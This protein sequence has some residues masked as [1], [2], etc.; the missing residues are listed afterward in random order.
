MVKLFD[1][2]AIVGVG[3][4]GGSIGID[5]RRLGLAGEVVGIGRRRSS[6]SKARRCGAIDRGTLDVTRGV[7]QADL[8]IFA[9]AVRTIPRLVE[10][11]LPI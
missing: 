4:I 8:V 9:T 10:S 7:S 5:S 11:A 1:R 3:L 2:I 6:L